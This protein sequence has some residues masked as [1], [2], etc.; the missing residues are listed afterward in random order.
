MYVNPDALFPELASPSSFSFDRVMNGMPLSSQSR[1][2][3]LPVEI[4]GCIS[5]Y[6]SSVDLASL[7]LV[8][9]DCRQLARS[10]QFKDLILNYREASFQILEKLCSDTLRRGIWPPTKES[11]L[12][13]CFAA[14]NPFPPGKLIGPCIRRLIIGPGRTWW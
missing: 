4:L 7:A 11:L 12:N 5:Q 9:S 1:L 10:Y 8:N 13:Q 14:E 6:S 3:N 2:L